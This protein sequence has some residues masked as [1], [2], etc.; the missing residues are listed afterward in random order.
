MT[1][2]MPMTTM[3]S[4]NT[5]SVMESNA[6]PFSSENLQ[7]TIDQA[8]T[9]GATL[10]DLKEIISFAK[11]YNEL[12]AP[13]AGKKLNSTQIQQSNNALSGLND[14]QLIRDT[15]RDK[16]NAGILNSLPGGGLTK[17]LAGTTDY[18]AARQNVADVIGRL[19]SGGAINKDE[20]KRFLSLLPGAFE[21]S[22]AAAN[23]LARLEELLSS[24]AY[25]QASSGSLEDVLSQGV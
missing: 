25:P 16:P 11:D 19:R 3:Q 1:T 14:I 17:R 12:I 20:E 6:S 7:M 4:N 13:A 10:K 18:E 9:N 23:K 24:F 22:T 5:T 21:D 8:L 2:N 15:L